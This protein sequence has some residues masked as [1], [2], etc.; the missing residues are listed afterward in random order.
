MKLTS[1]QQRI[2]EDW[3]RKKMEHHS[4]QLCQANSWKIGELI[5]PENSDVLE[6][7]TGSGAHMVQLICKNCA[8]VLL[9]DV[10]RIQELH[11]HDSSSSAIM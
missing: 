11:Q 5:V 3:L 1:E 10:R 8:N 9:F 2:F 4:C 6:E 7:M